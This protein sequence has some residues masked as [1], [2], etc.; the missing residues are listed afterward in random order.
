VLVASVAERMWS[1]QQ[2]EIPI[3][4]QPILPF[5]DWVKMQQGEVYEQAIVAIT[6][7]QMV[8]GNQLIVETTVFRG[9]DVWAMRDAAVTLKKMAH[10]AGFPDAVTFCANTEKY[11]NTTITFLEAII[12]KPHEW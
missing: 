2:Q 7:I 8:L 10:G 11:A 6:T 1:V 3:E 5:L 4:V 12:G 9:P